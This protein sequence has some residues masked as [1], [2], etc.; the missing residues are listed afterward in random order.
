MGWKKV[1]KRTAGYYLARGFCY[2]WPES[3][4]G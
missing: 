2:T 4:W 1:V 3:G